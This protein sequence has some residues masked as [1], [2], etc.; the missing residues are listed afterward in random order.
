M[1]HVDSRVW[2]CTTASDIQDTR[3][4]RDVAN[5][6]CTFYETHARTANR[7]A[8]PH[9]YIALDISRTHH[10]R[11]YLRVPPYSVRVFPEPQRSHF[12]CSLPL[13]L[14]AFACVSGP[15]GVYVA[16]IGTYSLR[17][18]YSLPIVIQF[19][20]LVVEVPRPISRNFP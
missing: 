4:Y 13:P 7:K 9:A 8:A 19:R 3:D 12:R 15:A 10:S 18:S 20:D 11:L 17:P 6:K 16:C 5:P 1:Q 2:P 14:Y